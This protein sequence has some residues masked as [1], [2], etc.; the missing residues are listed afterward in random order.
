[1]R[2]RYI[3]FLAFVSI[4]V[5]CLVALEAAIRIALGIGFSDL[6]V[7]YRLNDQGY[8]DRPFTAERSPASSRI[9]MVGAS[10]LFGQS[11]QEDDTLPRQLERQLR[12]LGA[13]PATAWNVSRQGWNTRAEVDAAVAMMDRYRFDSVILVQTY[14][15]I[16]LNAFEPG[17]MVALWIAQKWLSAHIVLSA[18]QRTFNPYFANYWTVTQRAYQDPGSAEQRQMAKALADL[19]DRCEKEKI[20][21]LVF[22]FEL[23]TVDG[24]HRRALGAETVRRL[25]DGLNIPFLV[26][27]PLPAGTDL[28]EWRAHPLD[29][30]PNRRG[31]ERAARAIAQVLKENPRFLGAAE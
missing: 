17:S 6:T 9:L 26:F 12:D 25:T 15:D 30:H 8:R 27:P 2:R 10:F 13:P 11:V 20:P 19:R 29:L 24:D 14:N 5:A 31:H 18:L 16:S 23:L 21:L 22:Y 4:A 7:I 28:N 3:A 1:V